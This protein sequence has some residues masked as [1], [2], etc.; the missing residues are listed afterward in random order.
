MAKV[1]RCGDLAPGCDAVIEGKD[2][3]ELMA[4]AQE[5]AKKDH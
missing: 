1:L 2:V 5:H 4:K 3:E